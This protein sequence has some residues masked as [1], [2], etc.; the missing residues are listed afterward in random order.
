MRVRVPLA[1]LTARW[2]VNAKG[3]GA[4]RENGKHNG[5]ENAFACMTAGKDRHN[6]KDSQ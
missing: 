4:S 1:Y 2:L 3:S 6:G 5:K